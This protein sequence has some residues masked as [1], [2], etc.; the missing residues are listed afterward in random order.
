MRPDLRGLHPD[1]LIDFRLKQG[2]HSTPAKTPTNRER[3]AAYEAKRQQHG[4]LPLHNHLPQKWH[5]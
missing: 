4:D 1:M 2:K 5:K 3:R